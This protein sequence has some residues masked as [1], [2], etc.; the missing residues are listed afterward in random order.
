MVKLNTGRIDQMLHEETGKKEE[1]STILRSI[2]TRYMHLYEDYFSDIEALNNEKIAEF[3]KYNEETQSLIKY[4]YLDIPLD[5]C[6]NIVEFEKEYGENLLGPG[7]HKYVFDAYKEF[8]EYHDC[9]NKD[10]IMKAFREHA[11]ENFYDSMDSI[12]RESFGTE[13]KNT[14]S[15]LSLIKGLFF[16]DEK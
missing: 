2:Y 16:D 11:I 9:K 14:E 6:E 12:F 13:S 3:R 4:Y 1:L 8:S 7:W 15:A 10:E 5:V